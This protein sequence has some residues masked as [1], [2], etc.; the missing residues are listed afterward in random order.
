FIPD[1]QGYIMRVSG[2]VLYPSGAYYLRFGVD[3]LLSNSQVTA[4]P[5]ASG[6]KYT[7]RSG[8]TVYVVYLAT[9]FS[10]LVRI[11]NDVLVLR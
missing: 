9:Q 3:I 4:G 8:S 2:D 10:E 5:S 1:T 6:V 7:Y 11:N